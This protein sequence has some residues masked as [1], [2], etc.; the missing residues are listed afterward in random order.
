MHPLIFFSVISLDAHLPQYYAEDVITMHTQLQFLQL[1]GQQTLRSQEHI[2]STQSF[3][4]DM[5]LVYTV[6]TKVD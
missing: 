6:L 1:T 5:E 3:T 2:N 4:G